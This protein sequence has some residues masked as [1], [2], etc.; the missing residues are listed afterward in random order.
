ML[1]RRAP[2][3]DDRNPKGAWAMAAEPRPSKAALADAKQNPS[4]AGR[5]LYFSRGA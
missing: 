4:S 3:R 1:F 2:F 5:S